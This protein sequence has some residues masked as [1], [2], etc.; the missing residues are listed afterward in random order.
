MFKPTEIII[1]LEP[2][3]CV[4]GSG[5]TGAIDPTTGI[6]EYDVNTQYAEALESA[7]RN[8]GIRTVQTPRTW[9][10]QTKI[11]FIAGEMKAFKSENGHYPIV[12][13]LSLHQNG[14][15][16]I[17]ANGAE[18]FVSSPTSKSAP[19]ADQVLKAICSYNLKNRGLKYKGFWI[20]LARAW[21]MAGI[22]SMETIYGMLLEPGFITNY[23]DRNIITDSNVVK[24][25]ARD[26]ASI[27]YRHFVEGV[28]V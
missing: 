24:S 11:N 25:L 19:I 26:I 8:V 12:L 3:H 1:A 23:H 7:F 17:T 15:A 22:G 18:I 28:F 16:D 4:K 27:V 13:W 10:T 14:F 5:V 2:G 6:R 9:I 21:A 20:F